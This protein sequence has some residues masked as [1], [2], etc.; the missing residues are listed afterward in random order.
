MPEVV[1]S[2]LARHKSKALILLA[3][4][5]VLDALIFGQLGARAA[6]G[7]FAIHFLNVGQGDATLVTFPTGVRMLIDG[8]PPNGRALGELERVLPPTDRYLDLV[9]MSHPELDHFGGLIEVLRRYRVGAF[10]T[11]GRAGEGAAYGEL[12]ATLAERDVPV[13]TIGQGDTITNARTRAD[14]LSPTRT[15]LAGGATNEAGLVVELS[16]SSAGEGDIPLRALFTADIGSKTE[17]TLL[18][19]TEAPVDVLKVAHHG[20][21]YSSSAAFLSAL[22]PALAVVEVG[23]N[24][25]GHPTPEALA[26]LAAAGAK[27]Y[28]TDGGTVTV[29]AE[30]GSLQIFQ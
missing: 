6:G 3:A 5:A 10:L 8:G 15:L 16:D 4:V 18:P 19:L 13:V 7:R 1:F 23:K 20:S 26:R 2:L 14:M 22:R 30:N 28:R 24:S 29:M 17:A 27:V 11:S 9:M 25:Y 21:K 12:Q